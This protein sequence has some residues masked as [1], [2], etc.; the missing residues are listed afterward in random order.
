T[1]FL[2]SFLLTTAFAEDARKA[3]SASTTLEAPAPND[4]AT[5]TGYLAPVVPWYEPQATAK[6]KSKASSSDS[7]TH[8]VVDLFGGFS[9]VRFNTNALG[10][11]GLGVKEHFN[12]YG[13]DANIAGNLNRWF[14]LVGDFGFYRIKDLPPN[15]TGSAYTYLFGPRFSM[16]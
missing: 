15:V 13:L 5:S 8:P 10:V 12:W 3:S 4:S 11:G 1:L 6:T 2:G 7:E 16:R 14:G 9:F